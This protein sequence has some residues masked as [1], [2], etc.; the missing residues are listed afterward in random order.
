[1]VYMMTAEKK[2]TYSK[3]CQIDIIIV[4]QHVQHSPR[5]PRTLHLKTVPVLPVTNLS[6]GKVRV[7]RGQF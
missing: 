3:L 6:S 4:F 5:I 2:T 1:M 7:I